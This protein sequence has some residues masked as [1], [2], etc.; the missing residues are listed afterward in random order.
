MGGIDLFKQ[1]CVWVQ[2][3]KQDF[4]SG[5]VAASHAVE[6]LMTLIDRHWPLVYSWCTMVAMFLFRLLLRWRGCVARGL[7]SLFTLGTTA[8]LVILWSCFVCLTS[9]TS[10]VYAILSLVQQK[11][12]K[13]VMED[14][15]VDG[16]Y[17]P[18]TKEAEDAVYS[19]SFS[20]TSNASNLSNTKKDASSSKVVIMEPTS[21]VEM[22]RI[23][24]SSNHYED[25]SQYHQ[26]KDGDGWVESGC[27]PVVMTLKKVAY[28]L[29][30]FDTI[31]VVYRC[32]SVLLLEI[33]GIDVALY[34]VHHFTDL[35]LVYQVEIPQ[36]FVCAESKVFDV[37]EWAICQ[38]MT[39]R[40]N[41][42]GPT[43]H[44]N[45]VALDSTGLGSDSSTYS[46]GLDA[47]MVVEDD[48]FE[49]WLQEAVASGIFSETPK[50]RKS[51]PFKI[52]QKGLKPWRR[53]P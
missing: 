43:F 2:F 36:A 51:W 21:L 11:E 39:C 47:K 4:V 23:M 26:A 32:P 37:S 3:Q 42:H 38:G 1:G 14:F 31:P 5:R 24:N 40:P 44:V 50:R 13:Q 41:T 28:D 35:F 30:S 33:I 16:E 8:L 29:N 53:S 17:S 48:E 45:M 19:K 9:M 7:R 25:C 34:V 52:N 22:E 46:W 49:L 27:Q 20:T 12:S 6:K 18:P 15:S 10:V